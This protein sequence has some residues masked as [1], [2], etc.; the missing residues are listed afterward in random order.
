MPPINRSTSPSRTTQPRRTDSSDGVST[1]TVARTQTHS[2]ALP[3]SRPGSPA[4]TRPRTAVLPSSATPV[5]GGPASVGSADFSASESAIDDV[6]ARL[7][8]PSVAQKYAEDARQGFPLLHEAVRE[9]ALSTARMLGFPCPGA[10]PVA[11]GNFKHLTISQLLVAAN[12]SVE[13]LDKFS[14]DL[15]SMESVLTT[16]ERVRLKVLDESSARLS[17][18]FAAL[19]QRPLEDLRK[20]DVSACIAQAAKTSKSLMTSLK[21]FHATTECKMLGTKCLNSIQEAHFTVNIRL[22]AE[23]KGRSVDDMCREMARDGAK[24][25]P[26]AQRGFMEKMMYESLVA[27]LQ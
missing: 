21:D 9:V 25:Q 10:S 19:K 7:G 14:R 20:P 16:D 24:N 1:A 17:G 18:A 22:A 5:T 23:A 3:S 8:D 13:D 27:S 15:K 4:G 11:P 26:E 6:F 2:P 12:R